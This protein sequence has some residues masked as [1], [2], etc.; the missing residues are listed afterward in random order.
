MNIHDYWA[1]A[2]ADIEIQNPVT[3][4]K[5]RLLTEYCDMRDGLR[6]LDIGCGKAWLLRQW[7]EQFDIE[8]TGLEINPIFAAF[9][10]SHSPRRGR[11]TYVEGAAED[12]AA[13]PGGYD[14]VMCLGATFALGGLAE[15]VNWMSRAVRSG[16]ALVVGD[17]VTRHRPAVNTHQHMPPDAAELAGIVQRNDCEVSAMISASEAD[18]ERYM[19]HHRHATVRWLLSHPDHADH[20]EVARRSSEEWTNYLRVV[21]PHLGWNIVVGHRT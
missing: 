13:E 19:S 8:A 5:L 17:L 7:A 4:R 2:E 14:V 6:V 3:D 9:A 20:D 15:A 21:R 11:I 1:I 10:R 16:G 18:F 12:F